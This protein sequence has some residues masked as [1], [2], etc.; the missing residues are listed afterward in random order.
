MVGVDHF[1]LYDNGS[2]DLSLRTLVPYIKEGVVTLVHWPDRVPDAG[3]EDATH[4]ALST[5]LPAYEHAVKCRAV[6]ETRWL[7]ILDV[8]E[9]LV[10]VQTDTVTEV[11]CDYEEYPG[12]QLRSDYFDASEVGL[13]PRRDLLISTVELTGDSGKSLQ[14]SVEK[15]IF[16]PGLQVSFQWPP[17]RC[18]F[19]G[20]QHAIVVGRDRLRI[21]KYVHRDLSLSGKKAQKVHAGAQIFTEQQIRAILECGFQIEDQEKVIH[22]LELALRKRMGLDTGWQW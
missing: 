20:K 18:Q 21:N 3:G 14:K 6:K 2:K 17:Y 10:P 13:F 15:T 7:L 16:R 22:R 19:K 9:F 8:D 1:Y 12:V 11:L 5:Q 4:W